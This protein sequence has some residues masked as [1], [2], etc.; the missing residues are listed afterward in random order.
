M[1]VLRKAFIGAALAYCIAVVPSAA[2]GKTVVACQYL[3][4]SGLDWQAGRWVPQHYTLPAP[5]FLSLIEGRL[6]PESVRKFFEMNAAP[7]CV[8]DFA[9]ETCIDPLGLSLFFSFSDM[10]GAVSRMLGS[11]YKVDRRDSLV[12]MPFVCQAI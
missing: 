2:V 7:H 11:A 12:V 4:A 1:T 9:L 3:A 8:A 6:D 5:F 10:Q